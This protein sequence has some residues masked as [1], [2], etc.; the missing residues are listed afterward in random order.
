MDPTNNTQKEIK[1]KPITFSSK[2]RENFDI[3]CLKYWT[4]MRIQN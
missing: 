4:R 1:L 2:R 3:G